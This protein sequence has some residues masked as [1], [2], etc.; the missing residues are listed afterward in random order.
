[1][2]FERGGRTD[3]FGNRYEDRYVVNRMIALL[4]EQISSITIEPVGEDESGV[5]LLIDKGNGIQEFHQCKA[6]NDDSDRWTLASLAK[7]KM[8]AHIRE[9]V[10]SKNE[11]YIWVSPLTF[12]G[13]SDLCTVARNSPSADIFYN[14]QLSLDR[15]GLFDQIRNGLG[16][17]ES[18]DGICTYWII[19]KRFHHR[20]SGNA[21]I[22][23]IFCM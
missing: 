22:R 23:S 10:K 12:I 7:H 2:A 16:L 18:E 9:H 6:R 15:K 5:D 13:L 8:F 14:W 19:A 1:M 4:R 21:L 3:K 17:S 20:F 11:F